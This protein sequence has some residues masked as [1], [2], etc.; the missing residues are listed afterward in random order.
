MR[1]DNVEFRVGDWD[2]VGQV[3]GDARLPDL[4]AP[5]ATRMPARRTRVVVE[6]D[7]LTVFCLIVRR[8]PRHARIFVSRQQTTSLIRAGIAPPQAGDRRPLR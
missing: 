7:D 8:G 5:M 6:I 4:L 2:A 1:F 3:A